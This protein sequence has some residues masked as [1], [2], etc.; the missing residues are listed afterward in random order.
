[1]KNIYFR[2]FSYDPDLRELCYYKLLNHSQGWQSIKDKQILNG[3]EYEDASVAEEL[4]RREIRFTL[5]LP[6]S[7]KPMEL[8]Q[9][10]VKPP[11][12]C[13]CIFILQSIITLIFHSY[14]FN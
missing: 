8:R 3:F 9:T 5:N 11:K 10:T 2:N 13:Y 7:S 14:N 4:A 12:V 1:M 6:S